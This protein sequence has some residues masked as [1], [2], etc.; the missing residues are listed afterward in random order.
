[1]NK[2]ELR[3]IYL[4]KRLMISTDEIAAKSRQ[5]AD[6]FFAAVDLRAVLFLHTFIPINK[7]NEV[8][9]ALIYEQIWSGFPAIK[10]VAP[11]TD[12]NRIELEHR[13]FNAASKL[14]ESEWGIR[15]PADG[16]IVE[17]SKIDI[18]LVPLLAFD[19][20]GNRVGYGKGFYDR[21]LNKCRA[22]CVK[23][24]LSLF[25]PVEIVEDAGEHDVPLNC[26]ITPQKIYSF[27]N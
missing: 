1:M 12:F 20:M 10:T 6:R 27:D 9:T 19:K 15:E 2:P 8:D 5:I 13:H 25:P 11:F 22:D 21:S 14:I 18:V 23:I 17:P 16:D 3:K 4:E 24:G 7:F 26:C